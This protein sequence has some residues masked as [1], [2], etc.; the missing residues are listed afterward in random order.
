MQAVGSAAQSRRNIHGIVATLLLAAFPVST[1][2]QETPAP[3]ADAASPSEPPP[4]VTDPLATV[5]HLLQA[6]TEV[7]LRM[8]ETVAS[9]THRRGDRFKLEVAEVVQLDGDVVIPAGTPAEGEVIHA[10][11]AGMSG[12]AGELILA[13]RFLNADGQRVLLR[14][15]SAGTGENRLDLAT[16]LGVLGGIPALFVTGKEIVIPEGAD[17]YAKVRS[18]TSLHAILGVQP[19]QEAPAAI[20]VD[21]DTDN[22]PHAEATE[23]NNDEHPEH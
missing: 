16:G 19:V 7:H 4:V 12:R 21:R 13:V 18:D 14:A 3:V 2:G 23:I 10:A 9:N 15:S 1:F 6:N 5:L 8:L 11:K 22:E 20:E 17:I